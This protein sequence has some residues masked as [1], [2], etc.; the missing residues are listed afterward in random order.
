MYRAWN[1]EHSDPADDMSDYPIV[2]LAFERLPAAEMSTRAREFYERIRTRRTVRDFS[3][4]PLPDDVIECALRAAGTAPS[5]ANHQ[6]WHFVVVRDPAVKR[7]IRIA[8]DLC[9]YLSM[10]ARASALSPKR[11]RTSSTALSI[12]ASS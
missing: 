12:G 5:G 6:P 1:F 4:E 8:A 7:E 11:S 9:S 3:S 2:P 10:R